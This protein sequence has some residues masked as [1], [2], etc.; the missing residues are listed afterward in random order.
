MID[1]LGFAQKYKGAPT[2]EER[3]AVIAAF[4][5]DVVR[6]F[7]DGAATRADA[8]RIANDIAGLQTK[9]D[10]MVDGSRQAAKTEADQLRT[11]V[12]Q[13]LGMIDQKVTAE[14]ARLDTKVAGMQTALEEKIAEAGEEAK[15]PM[16]G[17]VV[18]LLFTALL[19]IVGT[20]LALNAPGVRGFL[21]RTFGTL[22]G[23]A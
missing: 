21:S 6:Q 12:D 16:G 10:G 4:V 23:G 8:G 15:T 11:M 5:T 14:L 9:L 20:F 3:A 17:I 18:L 22:M 1:T 19:T 2:D 7:G 13:A